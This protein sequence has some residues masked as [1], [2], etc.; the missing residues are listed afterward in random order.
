MNLNQLD[1]PTQCLIASNLA[2]IV[3]DNVSK[4]FENKFLTVDEMIKDEDALTHSLRL[5]NYIYR[6]SF[7]EIEQGPAPGAHASH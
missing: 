3:Y 7:D 5:A 1:Y 6:I 4:N 2:K